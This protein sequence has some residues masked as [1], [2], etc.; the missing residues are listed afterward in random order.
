MRTQY[1][2]KHQTEATKTME[3]DAYD[4]RQP[5]SVAA[6]LKVFAIL[7]ALAERNEIG[8]SELLSLIHI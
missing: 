2:V 5:E 1:G 4:A 6:V 8:I 3:E 7:Q